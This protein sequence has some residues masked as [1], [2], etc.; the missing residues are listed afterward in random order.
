MF[1]S[2]IAY[3]DDFCLASSEEDVTDYLH[4]VRRSGIRE[5]RIYCTPS[6]YD[7]LMAD[8]STRFFTLLKNAGFS[9]QSISY[10]EPYGLLLAES[11]D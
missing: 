1:V 10:N 4:E 6:L 2:D 5:I 3:Y 8:Q 9:V 11:P 7:A